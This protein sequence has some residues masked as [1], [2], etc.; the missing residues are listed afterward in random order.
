MVL[1]EA[2]L[3]LGMGI[4]IFIDRQKKKSQNE[5]YE[6]SQHALKSE[7]G[8]FLVF[9]QSPGRLKTFPI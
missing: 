9:F 8:N 3:F 1:L 6:S 2:I 4:W 5:F 7:D